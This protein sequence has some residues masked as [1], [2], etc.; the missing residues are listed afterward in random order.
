MGFVYYG[1][2][3]KPSAPVVDCISETF[4]TYQ[5]VLALKRVCLAFSLFVPFV[6]D[7]KVFGPGNRLFFHVKSSCLSYA[8]SPPQ[9]IPLNLAA[10]ACVGRSTAPQQTEAPYLSF[11]A[12]QHIRTENAFL[13]SY[14]LSRKASKCL[15]PRP[16]KQP[17]LGLAT[18]SMTFASPALGRIF[19]LPTLMGF[20]LQSFTPSLKPLKSFD[21]NF[22]VFALFRK[23]LRLLAGA[24]TYSSSEKAVPFFATQQ[25]K[26]GQDRM[27]SWALWTSQGFSLF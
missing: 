3:P 11:A 13:F 18:P 23:T 4:E 14:S 6:K 7:L 25:V 2:P 9:R 1:C 16:W 17:S 5:N 10:F 20:A 24:L 15:W 26:S 27:L 12:L 19:H 21:L 8:F 22:S